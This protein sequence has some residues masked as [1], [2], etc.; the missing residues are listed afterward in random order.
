LLF[1]PR[2]LPNL[3][4]PKII[5]FSSEPDRRGKIGKHEWILQE[6]VPGVD[7][8]TAWPTLDKHQKT[9]LAIELANVVTSLQ[10]LGLELISSGKQATIG[11]L[12][13]T[14]PEEDKTGLGF[15]AQTYPLNDSTLPVFIS[16]TL[17][18]PPPSTSFTE[19]ISM[20]Y[21]AELSNLEKELANRELAVQATHLLR[22]KH[23]ARIVESNS[24]IQQINSDPRWT[25]VFTHGDFK[26]Q[27]I[28][29]HQTPERK[30]ALHILDWEWCG[31]FP[32]TTEWDQGLLDLVE[33]LKEEEDQGMDRL[34]LERLET[35][36]V[37]TASQGGSLWIAALKMT[38]LIECI[39]PWWLDVSKPGVEDSQEIKTKKANIV[40]ELGELLDWFG[41]PEA[42]E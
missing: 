16:N 22:L 11:N 26:P 13:L 25:S 34:F 36:G 10:S 40:A 28:L 38:R 35:G 42:V 6:R 1:V 41:A 19:Y 30:L 37:M 2:N 17:N 18:G 3:A 33:F 31:F 12:S 27:N 8:K 39:C 9:H 24:H 4:V 5:A 15:N 21:Q 29:V 23:F 20:L 7:L 14:P 32:P